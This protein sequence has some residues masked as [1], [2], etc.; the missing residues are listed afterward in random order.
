MADPRRAPHTTV[1]PVQGI[2]IAPVTQWLETNIDGAVGPFTFDLI[3]GGRSNLTYRVTDGVA[4]SDLMQA[5][6]FTQVDVTTTGRFFVTGAAV[7]PA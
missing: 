1:T 5:A 4:V 7:A 2:D 6:G 3:A